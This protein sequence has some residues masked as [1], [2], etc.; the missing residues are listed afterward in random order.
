[1]AAK[2]QLITIKDAVSGWDAAYNPFATIEGRPAESDADYRFR[3]YQELSKSGTATAPGIKEAVTEAINSDVFKDVPALMENV[4]RVTEHIRGKLE[5]EPG[6][7]IRKE[8]FRLRG[9][10]AVGTVRHPGA[11]LSPASV[12]QL[13]ELLL[14]VLPGI[15]LG[16][17]L[18]PTAV[19]A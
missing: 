12:G 18:N 6:S 5:Q 14:E 2:G 1:M 3:R 8:I 11:P 15:D 19:I 4:T 13:E 16:K 7:A 10:L 9:L 17:R